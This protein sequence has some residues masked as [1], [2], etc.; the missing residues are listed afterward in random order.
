M[1]PPAL[2]CLI[3]GA[4]GALT[5]F[6]S[7]PTPAVRYT[8]HE[9]RPELDLAQL[10]PYIQTKTAIVTSTTAPNAMRTIR[11]TAMARLW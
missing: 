9:A 5:R 1:Q 7:C 10:I 11:S 8:R 3:P 2:R 6:R 4:N